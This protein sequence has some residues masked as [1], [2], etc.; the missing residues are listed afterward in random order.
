MFADIPYLSHVSYRVATIARVL[1]RVSI[2]LANR[3]VESM[4]CHNSE[5]L[6]S[7][8]YVIIITMCRMKH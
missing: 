2:S 1:H 3:C 8:H 6:K 5:R 7:V 4:L